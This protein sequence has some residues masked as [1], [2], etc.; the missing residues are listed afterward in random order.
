MLTTF[1]VC[2]TG[3]A[4]H[5]AYSTYNLLVSSDVFSCNA[6]INLKLIE[7]DEKMDQL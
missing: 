7:S 6:S 4:G 3:A 5:I 1:N 2:V